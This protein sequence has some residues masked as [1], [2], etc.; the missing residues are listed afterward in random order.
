M[1]CSQKLCTCFAQQQ[2]CE[3]KGRLLQ[4]DE[5]AQFLMDS[6][7]LPP[8]PQLMPLLDEKLLESLILQAQVHGRVPVLLVPT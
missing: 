3:P 8:M 7:K 6:D 1:L 2:E 4:T 5:R